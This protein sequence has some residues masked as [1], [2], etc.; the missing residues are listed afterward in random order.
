MSTTLPNAPGT[1]PD[2]DAP[3]PAG[4]ETAGYRLG[5]LYLTLPLANI[6]LYM[7]W[8]G[9]GSF[10]IPFQ[11]AQITGSN[12]TDA[13]STASTTGAVLATV[14]N[15]L[16]GLLSDRTRSRFGRRTPWILLC[17]GVGSLAL[18]GQAHA[19]SIAMLG[20]SWGVVQFFL[21]GY[22]AASTAAMPDRVPARRYGVFSALVGLGIPLAT[23]VASLIIGGVP[24]EKFGLSGTIG[25]FDGRFMGTDGYYLIAA[26][27]MASALVFVVVSPDKSS[28][29]LP[30]EPFSAKEFLSGFWVS[31][32]RYPDFAWAFCSRFGVM[33]GYWIISVYTMYLLADY[34]GIAGEDL[35]AVMGFQ[36]IVNALATVAA[37]MLVGPL[38]DRVGRLKPF[39]LV[40][41]VG[42]AV[43]LAIPMLSATETGMTW[44][45][46]V[47]GVFFGTYMAVDLALMTRVLPP[48]A[49]VGKN[50]GLVNIAAAGPQIVAPT[51]AGWIVDAGGYDAMFPISAAVSLAGALLVLG[52]KGVK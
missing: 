16:F 2:T 50:L 21:N 30:R 48:A 28:K 35:G 13:L 41:G 6:A 34:I 38:V 22:M 49:E 52:V 9:V 37:S 4:A 24:G 44:F 42:S 17:A 51:V 10:L 15:P 8:I 46:I 11:V 25:G 29:D 12:D 43:S 7:I 5:P 3:G 45:Q 1:A 36:L 33:L 23:I 18:V 27:V 32:R 20:L 19:S 47:N 26:I 40:C 14:G 31:P 39:V